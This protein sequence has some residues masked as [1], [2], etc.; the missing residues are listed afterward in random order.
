[1]RPPPYGEE[2]GEDEPSQSRQRER[3]GPERYRPRRV[4]GSRSH[5]RL[6]LMPKILRYR[7]V[8]E[9][10]KGPPESPHVF[11]ISPTGRALRYVRVRPGRHRLIRLY[12]S[13]YARARHRPSPLIP[14]DTP[15]A[16]RA[17]SSARD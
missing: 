14:R 17:G 9:R 16:S 13:S 11:D 5:A 7:H 10:R 3:S 12:R 1:L 6:K 8:G 4:G 15:A 2:D